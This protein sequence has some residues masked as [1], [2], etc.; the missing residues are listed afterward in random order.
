VLTNPVVKQKVQFLAIIRK[1][2]SDFT[3]FLAKF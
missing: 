1:K 3:T 2:Q